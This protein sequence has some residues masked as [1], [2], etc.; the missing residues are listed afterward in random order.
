MDL[1]CLIVVPALALGLALVGH[2]QA[3]ADEERGLFRATIAGYAESERRPLIDFLDGA[4]ATADQAIRY[5]MDGK[6]DELYN[7]M[8]S[9]YREQLSVEQFRE[10]IAGLSAKEGRLVSFEYRNQ[11]LSYG[12]EDNTPGSGPTRPISQ[13]WYAVKTTTSN[14]A[15]ALFV[16][17]KTIKQENKHVVVSLRFASYRSKLPV[18]LQKQSNHP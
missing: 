11:A 1:R 13:V 18:W 5:V 2:G 15:D 14:E 8:V 17:V 7:V 16:I 10:A 6:A 3:P 4:R 9:R 12:T